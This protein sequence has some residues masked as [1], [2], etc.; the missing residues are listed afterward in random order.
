M[1][2]TNLYT[3]NEQYINHLTEDKNLANLSYQ[4]IIFI[5]L[6]IFSFPYLYSTFWLNNGCNVSDVWKLYIFCFN[7]CFIIFKFNQFIGRNFTLPRLQQ[8]ECNDS[9]VRFH[10]QIV[11]GMICSLPVFSII[12]IEMETCFVTGMMSHLI[13]CFF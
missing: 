2:V 4:I 13:K 8:I 3:H 10:S 1:N 5:F 6:G 7:V 9:G 12:N 11:Y